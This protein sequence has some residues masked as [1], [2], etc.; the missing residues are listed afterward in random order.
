LRQVLDNLIK[1]KR[2][3]YSYKEI[4][5]YLLQCICLRKLKKPNP[6]E[7]IDKSPNNVN[8]LFEKGNKKL[9]RELDIVNLVRAIRKL[10]LMAEVLLTPSERLLLKF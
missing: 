2:F 7:S 1:R 6:E 4:I 5:E 3:R 8:D 10:R 9:G